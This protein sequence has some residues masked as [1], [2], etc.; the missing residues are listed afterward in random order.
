MRRTL[1]PQVRGKFDSEDFVQAVWASF[2]ACPARWA[3]LH[4]PKQL[5]GL[6]RRM[7]RNKVIDEHRR[8]LATQKYRVQ[9][10]RPLQ[11]L[12]DGERLW[13][14]SSDPSPSQWAMAKERWRSLLRSQDPRHRAII[15]LK[16][17]GMTNRSVAERL[18]VSEKTVQRVLQ[19]IV[20]D[21]DK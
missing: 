8:R 21:A 11:V 14:Q 12:D 17:S 10:E 16:L 7:A 9:R 13:L 5:I 4:Q 18:R 15:R 1:N 2:F 20:R 19:Q 3:D 6:L